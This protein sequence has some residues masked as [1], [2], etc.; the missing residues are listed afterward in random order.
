MLVPDPE[1]RGAYFVRIAGVDHSHVDPDDPLRL[2]FDYMQ[3]VA[4]VID[5][6]APS[7]SRLRVVH[8]GGAGMTLAR[9]VAA[10]RPTSAQVVLEPDAAL[11]E[12]VRSVIPLPRR[13]GIK[14]RPVDG[15]TGMA[16]LGDDH[17]DLVIL[18][19][20]AGT[21]VPADLVTREWFADVARVLG[22]SGTFI[23]NLTDHAPFSWSRSAVAGIAE[24]WTPLAVATE[25]S[26]LAGRRFGNIVVAAGPGVDE[27]RLA[28]RSASAAFPYR[29]LTGKAVQRWLGGVPA[30][31]DADT[32]PS[33]P[34]PDGPTTFR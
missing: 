18:D 28:R 11:T 26:T 22:A 32:R 31:T 4:D 27:S 20:F 23:A 14:V 15:R 12:Q 33:P 6:M 25:P 8:V 17:A 24:R 21:Q 29:V 30:F 34:P 13:S 7:G 9:Y 10:T 1:V 3:R 19:A 5:T 16:Q 2:E